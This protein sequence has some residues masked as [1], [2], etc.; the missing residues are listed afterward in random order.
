MGEK[1]IVLVLNESYSPVISLILNLSAADDRPLPTG[2]Q[3]DHREKCIKVVF[4]LRLAP[5]KPLLSWLMGPLANQAN[6]LRAA[7]NA[8]ISATQHISETSRI[9]QTGFSLFQRLCLIFINHV[10][11]L[12]SPP[13]LAFANGYF[14][15]KLYQSHMFVIN[16]REFRQR[17][18]RTSAQKPEIFSI[19]YAPVLPKSVKKVIWTVIS[20]ACHTCYTVS[21]SSFAGGR[22]LRNA[23][24]QQGI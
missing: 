2:G 21:G 24:L 7:T 14:S 6:G 12:L 13:K 5:G 1:P 23:V 9:L 17:S 8:I 19:K 16:H 10:K 22:K 20:G 4:L 15:N 11:W 18:R 3:F